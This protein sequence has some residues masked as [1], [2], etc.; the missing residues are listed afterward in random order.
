M[1]ALFPLF[2]KLEGRKCLVVGAGS[3]ATGKIA[4]LLAT[5]ARIHVV[6]PQATDQ[7]RT[8]A[9]QGKLSWLSR[10]FKPSDLDGMFIVIA[11]TASNQLQRTIFEESRKRGV[12]ANVVD[13]PDLCD[14]YYPAV[15]RR[16]Q[17]QIAVS[18]AGRSPALAQRIRRELEEQFGDEYG[19]VLERL[20]SIREQLFRKTLSPNKRKALLHAVATRRYVQKVAAR[21]ARKSSGK[22]VS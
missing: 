2:L 22:D 9:T 15:V 13:V 16:G 4:G 17:L 14:F 19:P 6:A 21:V 20:G 3:I 10:R 7:I 1:P 18:T 11:A 12:L 5:G 8:W